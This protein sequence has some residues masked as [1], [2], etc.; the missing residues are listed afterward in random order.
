MVTS[1][2]CF[3][4]IVIF[5]NALICAQ[6]PKNIAHAI[7]IAVSDIEESPKKVSGGDIIDFKMSPTQKQ[8]NEAVDG[9]QNYINFLK[10][11]KP[12]AKHSAEIIQWLQAKAPVEHSI[13]NL[14]LSSEAVLLSQLINKF[15]DEK[16]EHQI[17]YMLNAIR[18]DELAEKALID[19][20]LAALIDV[21]SG[22]V[23]TNPFD[24]AIAD[25]PR[26][27]ERSFINNL[28]E[29]HDDDFSYLKIL[30][31][32]DSFLEEDPIVPHPFLPKKD[33][34]QNTWF[35]DVISKVKGYFR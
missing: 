5:C 25:Y 3:L 17:R 34:K 22:K 12:A 28:K 20:N 33:V 31:R 26:W 18:L 27:T 30:R 24:D 1:K 23:S 32:V 13:N 19:S 15:F 10:K 7:K 2:N 9:I 14:R 6:E 16:N 11:R 35:S 8:L 29:N 4:V 21:P